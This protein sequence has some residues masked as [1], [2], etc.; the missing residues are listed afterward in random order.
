[1][2]NGI[3]R[4]E[5]VMLSFD[6]DLDYDDRFYGF[7]R[8]KFHFPFPVPECV[9]DYAVAAVV[10]GVW[11]DLVAISGNYDRRRIYRFSKP[12]ETDSLRITVLATNGADTARI[13]EIR[14]Y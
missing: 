7:P 6:T 2:I 8:Q 13:Y 4:V 1:M 12:V 14:V 5:S 9:R 3:A 11:V 10:G